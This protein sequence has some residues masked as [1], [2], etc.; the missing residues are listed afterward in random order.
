[1]TMAQ[2][3]ARVQAPALSVPG[4]RAGDCRYSLHPFCCRWQVRSARGRRS[5]S[6][7]VHAP[8]MPRLR[9]STDTLEQTLAVQWWLAEQHQPV[10][11]NLG[12]RSATTCC[13][14]YES[15]TCLVVG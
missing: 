12:H 6:W 14:H 2:T 10:R 3:T 5:L 8:L 1:M 15:S 7:T 11:S 13:M 9:K 4:D